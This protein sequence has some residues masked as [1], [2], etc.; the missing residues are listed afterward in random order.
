DLGPPVRRGGKLVHPERRARADLVAHARLDGVVGQRWQSATVHS[1][2][3]RTVGDTLRS[4]TRSLQRREPISK[5]VVVTT[6]VPGMSE[7]G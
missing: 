2:I 4:R 6:Y 7:T 5:G 3:T 1:V